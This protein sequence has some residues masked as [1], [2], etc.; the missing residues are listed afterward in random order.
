MASYVAGN[1]FSC[2]NSR[3]GFCYSYDVCSVINQMIANPNKKISTLSMKNSANCQFL[4]VGRNSISQNRLRNVNGIIILM[5]IRVQQ[6]LWWQDD[7][8]DDRTI[9]WSVCF[10]RFTAKRLAEFI[11][12]FLKQLFTIYNFKDFPARCHVWSSAISP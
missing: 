7:I 12:K 10:Y 2:G 1:F 4:A 3:V 5:I 8:S 11:V 6:V 9:F